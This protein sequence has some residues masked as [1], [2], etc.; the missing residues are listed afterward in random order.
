MIGTLSVFVLAGCG[1]NKYDKS[2]D[3]V[4]NLEKDK[5]VW[6]SEEKEQI[7]RNKSEVWVFNDGKYIEIDFPGKDYKN[8]AIYYERY[9]KKDAKGKYETAN[10]DTKNY[11]KENAKLVYHEEKGKQVK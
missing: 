7:N 9:Y 2:I 1:S 3:T 5:N 11:I 8:K 4:F 6:N 10:F